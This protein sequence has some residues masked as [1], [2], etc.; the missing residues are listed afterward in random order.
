MPQ[1]NPFQ[2]PQANMFNGNLPVIQQD[3][4]FVQPYDTCVLCR[5]ANIPTE[6]EL[7]NSCSNSMVKTT[8]S[9]WDKPIKNMSVMEAYK[10]LLENYIFEAGTGNKI[11]DVL[12]FRSYLNIVN[13]PAIQI[14]RVKKYYTIATVRI[15]MY[16]VFDMVNLALKDFKYRGYS[17]TKEI[18]PIKTPHDMYEVISQIQRKHINLKDQLKT[19]YHFDALVP[20]VPLE[21]DNEIYNRL[22][23]S[24][25]KSAKN[26]NMPSDKLEYYKNNMFEL[27]QY[28]TVGGHLS[29]LSIDAQE[30]VKAAIQSGVFTNP[31][32]PQQKGFFNVFKNK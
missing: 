23:D 9:I 4:E 19:V 27:L 21:S 29:K 6:Y 22:K 15:C 11:F 20:P 30:Y 24:I 5:K 25:L 18:Y 3:E 7:C 10:S 2:N 31:Q 28:I 12:T 26:L 17:N 16:I 13:N 14:S 1:Q 32:Q 8:Q